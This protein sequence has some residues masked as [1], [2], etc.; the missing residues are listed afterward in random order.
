VYEKHLGSDNES[1]LAILRAIGERRT[2]PK[3]LQLLSSLFERAQFCDVWM[4]LL[5]FESV[6]DV[7]IVMLQRSCLRL[8][9][10][11]R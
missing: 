5:A 4:R 2:I 3:L 9:R 6:A 7:V 11:K 8:A 1:T 10:A